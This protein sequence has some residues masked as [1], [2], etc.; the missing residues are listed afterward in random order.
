MH[1]CH[2]CF[3]LIFVLLHAQNCSEKSSQKLKET[4]L[5][6]SCI[7]STSPT[8]FIDINVLI[9]LLKIKH[10]LQNTGLYVIWEPSMNNLYVDYMF[11]RKL[12]G[13]KIFRMLLSE[14][15]NIVGWHRSK[16]YMC[17]GDCLCSFYNTLENIHK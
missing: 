8:F 12:I 1:R 11:N 4:L 15:R 16:S 6:V 10:F 17:I 2:K 13:T 3:I 7:H 5:F 9:L 14:K